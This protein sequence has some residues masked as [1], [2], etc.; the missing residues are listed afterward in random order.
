LAA[1]IKDAAAQPSWMGKKWPEAVAVFFFKNAWFVF[2]WIGAKAF[3][4]GKRGI[5]V[6][7]NRFG[8]ATKMHKIVLHSFL[9]IK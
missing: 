8:F 2:A 1:A 3:I 6:T 9:H 4:W 5:T 7:A